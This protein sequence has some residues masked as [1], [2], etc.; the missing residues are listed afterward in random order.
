MKVKDLLKVS[1]TRIH[2]QGVKLNSYIDHEYEEMKKL[3]SYHKVDYFDYD[4]IKE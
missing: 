2:I 3:F 4:P 1:G